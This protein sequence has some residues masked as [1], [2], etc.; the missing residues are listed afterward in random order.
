M[1]SDTLRKLFR[2][3]NKVF[4]FHAENPVNLKLKA[5]MSK[6]VKKEPRILKMQ[7]NFYSN[8]NKVTF[9]SKHE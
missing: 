7:S 8:K 2:A 4:N 6:T 3:L 1:V 9:P 5:F